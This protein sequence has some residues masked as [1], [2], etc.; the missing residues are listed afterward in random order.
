MIQINFNGIK[1][2]QSSFDD[3]DLFN[4]RFIMATLV[5]TS[6]QNCN[7]KRT[8]FYGSKR[9]NVSFKMSNTREALFDLQGSAISQGQDS[10]TN[11]FGNTEDGGSL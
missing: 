6:M 7:L 1:A 3:S 11:S 4:S 5:D 9:S 8:L 10:K 2:Y